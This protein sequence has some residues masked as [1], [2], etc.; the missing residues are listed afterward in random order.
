MDDFLLAGKLG[1]IFD[2]KF[3]VPPTGQSAIEH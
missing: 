2:K 1:N 3:I